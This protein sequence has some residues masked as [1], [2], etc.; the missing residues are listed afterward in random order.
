MMQEPLEKE[1]SNLSKSLN[2]EDFWKKSLCHIPSTF[3]ASKKN[4]SRPSSKAVDLLLTTSSWVGIDNDGVTH[5]RLQLESTMGKLLSAPGPGQYNPNDLKLSKREIAPRY[6]LGN[7]L[8]PRLASKDSAKKEKL[9]MKSSF[10]PLRQASPPRKESDLKHISV[11]VMRRS[12][13]PGPGSY[14]TCD[15][16]NIVKFQRV[17]KASLVP[18]SR[19]AR[20][21]AVIDVE[22]LDV[23][24]SDDR[25]QLGARPDVRPLHLQTLHQLLSP[26]P[27]GATSLSPAATSSPPSSP[28][29]S[30]QQLR[31]Q[32]DRGVGTRLGGFR[33]GGDYDTFKDPTKREVAVSIGERRPLL[34]VR[35]Q[36]SVGPGYYSDQKVFSFGRPCPV[37]LPG[38]SG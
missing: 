16:D 38:P 12:L 22:T 24:T 5:S 7:R 19:Q 3:G 13:M 17:P 28:L 29:P 34:G 20:A 21:R 8:T 15:L 35:E 30:S 26:T 6:S 33:Y 23:V 37:S 2:A 18:R 27:L 1:R 14:R 11:D 25:A 36:L 31:A 10:P 32:Q 4:V 9:K